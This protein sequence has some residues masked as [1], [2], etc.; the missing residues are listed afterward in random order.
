LLYQGHFEEARQ[1]TLKCLKLLPPHAPQR[2]LAQQQLQQCERLLTLDKRRAG[3][4][5]GQAQAKN[6]AELLDLAR[7]CRQYKRHYAAAAR[8]YGDAFTAEPKWAEQHRY[9]AACCAALAGTGQGEDAASLPDQKRAKLRQQALDWLQAGL[10]GL[11]R[12]VTAD[13]AKQP[14]A[15]L[16]K[17]TGQGNGPSAVEVVRALDT[18][19]HW[20]QVPDL[21][22]VREE[23]ELARLTA[24]EQKAWRALWAEVAAL[25]QQARAHFL[26]TQHR[27][28]LTG[29]QRAQVHEVPLQAGK[30][31]V[32]DLESKDF[33]AF[34]RL[35]DETGQKLA[36]NDDI[37]P[38]VILNS[39]IIFTAAKDGRYR[40]VA[41]SFMGWG[42]GAYVLR[43]R[44]FT[45]PAPPPPV[46]KK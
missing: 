16:E 7:L 1:A 15:P 46:Q 21:A 45:S 29:K 6:P 19:A 2:S 33:D 10:G 40:L 27:G 42:T 4:L 25:Q 23:K 31:Y 8:F 11:R 32:F 12:L 38:K 43:L 22:S 24:E 18:L 26:E 37:E 14:A 34:L 3:I 20:Q 41:T 5:A 9:V 44:E 28:Q 35:E 13:L 30:T 36:E 17:R 39:R